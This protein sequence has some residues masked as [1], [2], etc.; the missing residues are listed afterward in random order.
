MIRSFFKS[1]RGL[2]FPCNY[3]DQYSNTPKYT[4]GIVSRGQGRRPSRYKTQAELETVMVHL[5]HCD[6]VFSPVMSALSSP[7]R[8]GVSSPDRDGVSSLDV[9]VYLS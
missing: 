7:D 8:D 5:P 1:G 3:R 2:P 4:L 6:G 9:M